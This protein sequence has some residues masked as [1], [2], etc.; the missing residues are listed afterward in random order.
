MRIS[1]QIDALEIMGIST[2][3]YLVGPKILAAV[4]VVPLLM[5]FAV[6]FGIYG[7]LFA[8]ISSGV[9]SMTEYVR[10]L[11]DPMDGFDVWVMFLKAVTFAF[12]ITSVSC[13]QGFFTTGGALDIGKASTRAVVYSSIILIIA[14][15]LIATLVL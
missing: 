13:Y 14:N 8:G 2:P 12:I 6:F 1:E 9:Y 10:G 15:F 11:Q 7:G 4:I 5:I 3:A